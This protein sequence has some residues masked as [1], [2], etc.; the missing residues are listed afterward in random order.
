L[1]LTKEII[2][3]L[4]ISTSYIGIFVIAELWRKFGRPDPEKTRKFVHLCSG[5]IC[6]T[7]SYLL[8]SHFT[9]LLLAAS[10]AAIIWITSKKGWLNS[11]HGVSRESSGGIYFPIAIYLTFLIANVTEQPHLYLISI[12]V[13]AVSDT[14]AALIGISYGNKKFEVE[15]DKKSLEGT[16]AFFFA[17][18]IL[19]QLCLLLLTDMGRPETVL[20]GLYVAILVTA[21]ELLSLGGAD[22]LFIP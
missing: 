10:F 20:A 11:V 22:N 6:L 16:L 9:V 14:L 8:Q 19:V 5:A 17:T 3:V 12:L 7:F 1:D 15:D 4:I 2:S 18:F 21:I 13:L